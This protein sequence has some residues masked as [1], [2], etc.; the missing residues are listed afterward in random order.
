MPPPCWRKYTIL[1]T[2]NYRRL[3]ITLWCGGACYVPRSIGGLHKSW[4]AQGKATSG[5]RP[6]AVPL[7][8]CQHTLDH[9]VNVHGE[10][11]RLC[12]VKNDHGNVSLSILDMSSGDVQSPPAARTRPAGRNVIL[13]ITYTG[14]PNLQIVVSADC[15]F[16]RTKP[17]VGSNTI[18]YTVTPTPSTGGKT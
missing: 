4:C 2:R 3:G 1:N 5:E 14:L 11:C 6:C 7:K 9:H 13:C 17:A 18:S 10:N 15:Q 16:W 8:G 12:I